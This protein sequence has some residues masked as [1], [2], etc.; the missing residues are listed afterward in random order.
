VPTGTV[1][2]D[3]SADLTFGN[4]TTDNFA[5]DGQLDDIRLY[6]RILTASEAAGISNNGEGTEDNPQVSYP[7]D[8]YAVLG[9]K[10]LSTDDFAKTQITDLVMISGGGALGGSEKDTDGLTMDL[11]VQDTSEEVTEA[12]KA[13]ATPQ[14]TYTQVGPGRAQNQRPRVTGLVAGVKLSN[15]VLGQTWAFEKVAMKTKPFGRHK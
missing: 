1:S 10:P 14:Y 7:I 15:E 4:K 13:G 11:H 12:I 8:S 3:A 5:F 6:N 9:P 2:S